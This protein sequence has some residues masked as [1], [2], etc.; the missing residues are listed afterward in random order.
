MRSEYKSLDNQI[1]RLR[2]QLEMVNSNGM[3]KVPEIVRPQGGGKPF[4]YEG[5]T[6]E[7]LVEELENTRSELLQTR[8][9]DPQ[10]PNFRRLQYT[11]Y[12][13]DFLLGFIG[14][15]AEAQANMEEVKG[16]LQTA[17][18]L[19]CSAVSACLI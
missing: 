16:F 7:E 4:K 15:K 3:T 8:A 11:R 2:R 1:T 13:D 17:L 10:D 12:A 6:R 18:Q 14:S 9:K 19:E 5:W